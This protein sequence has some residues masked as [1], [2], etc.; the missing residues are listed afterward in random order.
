MAG[1]AAGAKVPLT[2]EE[3][4]HQ[5]QQ[6]QQQHHHHTLNADP[7]EES[8][9]PATDADADAQAYSNPPSGASSYFVP[10]PN[11]TSS[12]FDAVTPGIE[13]ATYVPEESPRETRGSDA[14]RSARVSYFPPGDANANS[15]YRGLVRRVTIPFEFMARRESLSDIRMANPDL[16]LSGNIIS[17]TFNLPHAVTYCKGGK[18][19]SFPP[20]MAAHC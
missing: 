20:S 10:Q 8:D 19:V 15:A 13:L 4:Q 7:S 2:E 14:H 5:Q 11:A 18:W 17:A 1:Q 3:Q 12:K 6:Q 9:N 16:S